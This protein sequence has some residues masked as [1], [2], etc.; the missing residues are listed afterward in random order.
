MKVVAAPAFSG[1]VEVA[2]GLAEFVTVLFSITMETSVLVGGRVCDVPVTISPPIG[3]GIVWTR[4]TLFSAKVWDEAGAEMVEDVLS[5]AVGAAVV[6][7]VKVVD[8]EEAVDEKVE[9]TAEVVEEVVDCTDD[10]V[11]ESLG[12]GRSMSMSMGN[13]GPS[14][15]RIKRPKKVLRRS[16]EDRNRAMNER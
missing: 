6:D 15:R 10:E 14:C 9:D 1:N 5:V 4:I 7:G 2:D 8:V 3:T 11:P 13:V 12:S 16:I